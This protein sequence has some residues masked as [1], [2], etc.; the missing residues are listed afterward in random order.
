[1]PLRFD[2]PIEHPFARKMADYIGRQVLLF[3]RGPVPAINA[4]KTAYQMFQPDDTGLSG[5]IM[6]PS[7]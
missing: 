2:L 6:R 3:W 4:K 7:P 5:L 1:L